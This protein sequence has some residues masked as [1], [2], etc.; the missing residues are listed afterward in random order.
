M[1]VLDASAVLELLLGTAHGRRVAA[2]LAEADDTL[3]APSLVDVEVLHVLR[4]LTRSR[5]LGADEAES[6]LS[7]LEALD[8]ERHDHLPVLRRAWDLRANVSA[9]DAVYVA[10][11]EA[12]DAPLLTCDTKLTRATGLEAR[13]LHVS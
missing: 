10:L 6:A 5:A 1:I 7:D 9:Y 2:R 4:R 12:L 3:H 13:I 11:A 8:L